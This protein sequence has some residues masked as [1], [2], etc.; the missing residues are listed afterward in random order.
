[1]SFFWINQENNYK[2]YQNIILRA[3]IF[4]LTNILSKRFEKRISPFFSLSLKASMAVEAAMAIPFFLFFFINILSVFDILRLHGNIMAGLHQSGNEI[5]FSE[6]GGNNPFGSGIL[7]VGYAKG[8]VTRL[9]GV[10]YLNNTC[11][12]GGASGLHFGESSVMKQGDIVELVVSYQVKPSIKLI[13]FSNFWMENKY[14][15]R[16]WTGYD[17]ENKESDASQIDPV[18]YIA[19]SG[20]VYHTQRN[21]TYL[22]PSVTM[23]SDTMIEG[24]RNEGGGKYLPCERCDGGSLSVVVYITSDGNR[25]HGSLGC[26]GLKR[27]VYAVRLSETAGKG[28]CSKCR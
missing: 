5:A 15:G 9:L 17:V 13:G 23:I 6:Y 19:K 24:A 1:M 16:A 3:K 14:Y 7:A 20:T 27:T 28:K 22:N 26:P 18:V 11:L 12:S 10:D 21:C 2:R 8:K 25:Y 4:S